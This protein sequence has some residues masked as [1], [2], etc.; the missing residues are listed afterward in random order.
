MGLSES[1]IGT[2]RLRSREDRTR[3]GDLRDEPMLGSRPE[4]LLIYDRAG[5]FAAQFMKRDR[6]MSAAPMVAKQATN[7]SSAIGGYDAYFGSYSV[8]DAANVVTQ[9]LVAALSPTD[10]G[11][12]VTR[13]MHIEDSLLVIRIE[14]TAADG[15][16]VVRTL[17]WAREA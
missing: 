1:L 7:N 2:W 12:V 3:N 13:E 4:A 15:E 17:R 9:R 8:D 5:N 16:P 10:V 6:S 14:L 11:K